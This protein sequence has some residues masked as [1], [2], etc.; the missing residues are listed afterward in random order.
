MKSGVANLCFLLFLALF[1][2]SCARKNLS[3]EATNFFVKNSF[4]PEIFSGPRFDTKIW[5]NF[6]ATSAER[7]P[8]IHIVLEG[9][10]MAWKNKKTPSTNPTP[11]QI[12]TAAKLSEALAKRGFLT[13]YWARPCQYVDG[14]SWRD[15][16]IPDWTTER[17]GTLALT[18]YQQLFEHSAELNPQAKFI[19]WGYSGGGVLASMLAAQNPDKICALHTLA[20]PLDLPAWTNFH[21]ITP[22]K[23]GIHFSEVSAAN[24]NLPQ[25]HFVGKKDNIIPPDILIKSLG[26]KA[27]E[28]LVILE[29]TSH[30]SG[31]GDLSEVMSAS[32]LTCK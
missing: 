15:C 5:S 4:K 9:D 2:S 16:H 12:S 32:I 10:G 19:F 25:R 17:F 21:K 6:N 29:N 1:A 11:R 14:N 26:K 20:A 13:Q 3:A 24:K 28:S 27:Y 22:L 23:A 30:H 18:H 8:I 7:A 31:W